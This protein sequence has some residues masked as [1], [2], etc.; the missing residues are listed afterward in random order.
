MTQKRN[1]SWILCAVLVVLLTAMLLPWLLPTQESRYTR[2]VE[3]DFFSLGMEPLNCTLVEPFTLQKGDTIDVSVD[4]V[5]G[6]LEITIGQEHP[7]QEL[8][9][10]AKAEGRT[11]IYTSGEMEVDSRRE[12][13]ANGIPVNDSTLAELRT[14]GSELGLDFDAM[15]S[16]KAT[17]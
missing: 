3:E 16:V 2:R 4:R 13:L 15:V 5:S 7:L 8:R 11:R 9:D 10:S 1:L 6:E 17:E 12:K 14:V